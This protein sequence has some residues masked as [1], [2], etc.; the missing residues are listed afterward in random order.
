MMINAREPNRDVLN[1]VLDVLKE[2]LRVLFLV[3]ITLLPK[4]VIPH[5]RYLL[6][7]NGLSH[8]RD[9]DLTN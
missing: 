9:V 8:P 6:L 7:E 3:E 1:L 2:P 4:E 5:F